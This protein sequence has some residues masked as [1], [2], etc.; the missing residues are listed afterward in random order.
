MLHEFLEYRPYRAMA[1]FEREMG[2]YVDDGEVARLARYVEVR[3]A[4]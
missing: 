2:K 3:T 4:N 1:Q